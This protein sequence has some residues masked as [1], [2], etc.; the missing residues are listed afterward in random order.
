MIPAPLMEF[1]FST[2]VALNEL[3]Q[4]GEVYTTIDGDHYME[5]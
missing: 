4:E 2:R 1:F 5:T 3:E